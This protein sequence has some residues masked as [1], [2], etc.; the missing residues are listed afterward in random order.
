MVSRLILLSSLGIIS[1]WQDTAILFLSRHGSSVCP[2]LAPFYSK[3]KKYSSGSHPWVIQCDCFRLWKANR[4]FMQPPTHSEALTS[5]SSDRRTRLRFDMSFPVL[6]RAIGDPWKAGESKNIGVKGA[7]ILTS[8]PFLLSAGVECVL[9][10]PPQVTKAN[11]PL[12][13]RFIGTVLRCQSGR[14]RDFSFGIAL[15]SHDYRYLP[16]EEAARFDTIFEEISTTAKE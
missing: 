8:N 2:P 14:E 6:L 10:L 12:M 4:N 11:R 7:F 1:A 5:H 15:E 3:P 9:R 13:I 16:V